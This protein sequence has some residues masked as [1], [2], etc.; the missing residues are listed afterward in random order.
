MTISQNFQERDD[1]GQS[2]HRQKTTEFEL[3]FLCCIARNVGKKESSSEPK[4]IETVY[5]VWK[6]LETTKRPDIGCWDISKV[7]EAA[8]VRDEARSAGAKVHF[9]WIV[10]FCAEKGS[11]LPQGHE[12]RKYKK[13]SRF[14]GRQRPRRVLQ[15]CR[16]CRA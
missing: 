7:R 3:P 4:A 14:L 9:G 11:E 6:K 10:F 8:R 12:L 5:K 13:A 2:E 15:L 1:P 16:V